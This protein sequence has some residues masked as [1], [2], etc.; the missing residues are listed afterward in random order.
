[1]I[2]FFYSTIFC[3]TSPAPRPH[4]PLLRS[5]AAYCPASPALAS[6]AACTA[7]AAFTLERCTA[8]RS[9]R[10]IVALRWKCCRVH[11]H[12]FTKMC[13]SLHIV[14]AATC[15]QCVWRERERERKKKELFWPYSLVG[16]AVQHCC[17]QTLRTERA[18]CIW[19]EP[20]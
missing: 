16:S 6:Y 1:M 13:G 3:R 2:I 19:P 8:A 4:T 5:S 18:D 10:A 15:T 14:F 12:T 20:C 9:A 11:T 7:A 17:V